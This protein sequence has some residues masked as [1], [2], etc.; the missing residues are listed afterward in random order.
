MLYTLLLI[1]LILDSILLVAA[2]LMQAGQGG[3]MAASFG[4]VSSS[5]SS[6]LGTRQA[7]NLLTKASWWCGGLFLG[8]SF[9]LALASTRGRAPKS[10]LDQTFAPPPVSAPAPTPATGGANSAV[11]GLTPANPAPATPAPST[12]PATGAKKGAAPTTPAPKKP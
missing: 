7:G 9:L 5:A 11:P 10:V 2:I 1:L 4:G 3:G 8:L 12:A 6:F